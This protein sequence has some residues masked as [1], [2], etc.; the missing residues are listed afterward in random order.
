MNIPGRPAYAQVDLAATFANT[1]LI[2]KRIAP[3]KLMAVVKANAYGHGATK[4]A[5]TVVAAGADYLAVATVEEAA[6]L[7]DSQINCPI[8][9]LGWITSA[10]LKQALLLN[11]SLSVFDLAN[12]QQI[13]DMAQKLG[14]N[15]TIHLKLD[16]GMSRLGFSPN[17]EALQAIKQIFSLSH[18]KVEGLFSH[19]AMADADNQPFTIKQF[20]QFCSFKESA[21]KMGLYFPICHIANSPAVLNYPQAYLDM[22]R[23][24]LLL[25]GYTPDGLTIEDWPLKPALTIK[26]QISQIRELACG[27]T[28]GYGRTWQAKKAAKIATL[29]LGYADGLPRLLSNKGYVLV[30]GEKMPIIGKVCMDH[31]MV[32]ISTLD[33][34]R[35]GE[36][37]VILGS[38]GANHLDIE[39]MAQKAETISYELLTRFG[40]RLPHYY[41]DF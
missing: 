28:V 12:A 9:I 39:Q 1:Q 7:R 32:D 36:E 5:Q 14:I 25:H 40:Q 10:E 17:Q 41:L 22:V 34:V 26:A 38:Q 4:I 16:T 35:C 27:D 37:A 24:G 19:F 29:P 20:E 30:H 18:L 3:A 15:A 23:P 13:N 33:D 6:I 21:K 8:L 31:I 11:A 2:K